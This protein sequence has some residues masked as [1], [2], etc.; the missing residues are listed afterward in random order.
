MAAAL[1]GGPG[2]VLSHHSAAA[3]WSISGERGRVEISTP[4]GHRHRL[5]GVTSHRRALPDSDLTTCA[6]IPLTCVGAHADRHCLFASLGELE[7]AV[8]ESDRLDLVDPE[9][10]RMALDAYR[11]H[12]AWRD[13]ATCSIGVRSDSRIRSWSAVLA[14]GARHGLRAVTQQRLNGF[15]VD[16]FWPDLG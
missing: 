2:A 14:A 13:C 7:R 1:A 15:K 8:N 11:G 9:A 12:E 10:L 3:L 4:T 6:G 5:A 16:F